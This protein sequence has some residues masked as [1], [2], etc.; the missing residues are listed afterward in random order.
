M[1]KLHPSKKQF[2]QQVTNVLDFHTQDADWLNKE[3]F[4]EVWSM[5]DNQEA[6]NK[7][8]LSEDNQRNTVLHKV[9]EYYD[10][11]TFLQVW[12]SL[13]K[14]SRNVLSQKFN[15]KNQC[16]VDLISRK[17]GKPT[18]QKFL[19]SLSEEYQEKVLLHEKEKIEKAY[20]LGVKCFYA[21]EH[22]A[23]F[24]L[25]KKAAKRK[26]TKASTYKGIYLIKGYAGISNKK[27]GIEIIQKSL[28]ALQEESNSGDIEAS[29]LLAWLYKSGIGVPKSPERAFE[30]Y[31]ML[32]EKYNNANAQFNAGLMLEMGTGVIQD[33]EKAA[34][35]YR[36]A[37]NQKHANAR[38]RLGL[39]YEREIGAWQSNDKEAGKLYKRA[40]VDSQHPDASYRLAL[41]YEEGRGGVVNPSYD[42]AEKWYK[43]SAA[44]G[45]S[46]ASYRLER[47]ERYHNG[48][49]QLYRK[50]T[51]DDDADA[52][53]QLGLRFISGYG[54]Y[55]DTEE[56][57][58]W[59]KKA[60]NKQHKDAYYELGKIFE[61]GAYKIAKNHTRALELYKKA[62][63]Q[64]HYAAESAYSN[65]LDKVK[66]TKTKKFKDFVYR[67]QKKDLDLVLLDLNDFSLTDDDIYQLMEAALE[68][69]TIKWI[70][71]A[72]NQLTIE[73]LYHLTRLL[74]ANKTI[75]Q[76]ELVNNPVCENEKGQRIINGMLI[77]L[78]KH[79][80]GEAIKCKAVDFHECRVE[81]FWTIFMDTLPYYTKLLSLNLSQLNKGTN[82]FFPDIRDYLKCN[83]TLNILD[84][85]N[86]LLD[87]ESIYSLAVAMKKNRHL[88]YINLKNNEIELKK[89]QLESRNLKLKLNKQLDRIDVSSNFFKKDCD[90]LLS[91]YP[92]TLFYSNT[93]SQNVR[94]ILKPD[95]FLNTKQGDQKW[96][97]A[98]VCK[99]GDQH[100]S[101]F[102]EGVREA[103]GQRFLHKYHI[104]VEGLIVLNTK[105]LFQDF[106]LEYFDPNKFYIS[107]HQINEEQID[108]LCDKL[109]AEIDK[110]HPFFWTPCKFTNAA[111]ENTGKE[112][113][114]NCTKW[115]IR[116]LQ[117]AK[118]P[119]E[120]NTIPSWAAKMG[121]PEE[122]SKL[123][124]FVMRFC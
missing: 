33:Y 31:Q 56:A 13:D 87:K 20:R 37:V 98:L 47:L 97:V 116:V 107:A 67:L 117:Y 28:L 101:I 113:V 89:S 55:S 38:Y 8:A 1:T 7:T 103:S 86:N 34:S 30:L 32:S 99:K 82:F 109:E 118:V 48:A 66:V 124:K 11:N 39:L 108:M 52:Q 49:L 85:S 17:F 53:Y 71:L 80:R 3:D 114:L 70:D 54:V 92:S 119:V 22:N 5:I 15:N 83:E 12:S 46:D 9:I 58:K 64:G 81:I 111:K 14:P 51:E 27:D 106:D 77:P 57:V 74:A 121:M 4:L 73:G 62:Q 88:R 76:I 44:G 29:F 120:E 94:S 69:K 23:A 40:A 50:A 93:D 68:N 61:D 84:L 105:T 122:Q 104:K 10:S 112:E 24:K 75:Q 91:T 95:L 16:L 102:L 72:N 79:R 100:A 42:V 36:K 115:C 45:C 78:L 123:Q 59:L 25:F 26:H 21:K 63:G 96:V 65:L 90:P 6:R 60:V 43:T 19:N 2:K 41:M 110:K 18:Y 35:Y